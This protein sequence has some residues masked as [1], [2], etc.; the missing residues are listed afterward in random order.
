MSGP[1]II[2][3]YDYDDGGAAGLDARVLDAL[4]QHCASKN[5]DVSAV[6]EDRSRQARADKER[7][8]DASATACWS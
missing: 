1:L 8:S 4:E 2:E 3:E 6:H 5:I 7:A